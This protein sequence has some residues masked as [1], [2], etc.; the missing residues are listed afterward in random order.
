MNEDV[1]AHFEMWNKNRE[2]F[3]RE[4]ERIRMEYG[5]ETFLAIRDQQIIDSGKSDMDLFKKYDS[6]FISI[7]SI[8]SI[9][10]VIDMSSPE[11]L[12]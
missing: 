4:K 6:R 7:M 5:E 12:L 9:E 10:E 3:E 11:G 8:K 1:N 2:Y